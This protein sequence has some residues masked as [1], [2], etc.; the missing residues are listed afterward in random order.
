ME[1]SHLALWALGLVCTIL[2]WFAR[3]LYTAMQTLRNDLAVLE[4]RITSDYVR[5]DRMV[6]VMK[7]ILEALHDIKQEIR[8]KADKV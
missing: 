1:V 4:R 6:D 5:Y 2:G 8:L 7:P 3:E